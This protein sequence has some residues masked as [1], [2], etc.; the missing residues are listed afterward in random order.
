[1]TE[2]YVRDGADGPLK[3]IEMVKMMADDRGQC[4]IL[5]TSPVLVS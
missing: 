5:Q 1:M 4:I 2:V 3:R